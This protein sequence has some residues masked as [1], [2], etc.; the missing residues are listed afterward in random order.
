[1]E[2][3]DVDMMILEM[4]MKVPFLVEKSNDGAKVLPDVLS[5]LGISHGVLPELV[6]NT[7]TFVTP[8]E[9]RSL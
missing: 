5:S 8:V 1:M 9:P 3:D 4:M 6:D 2:F 7:F